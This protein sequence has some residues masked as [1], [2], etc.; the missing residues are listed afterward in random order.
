MHIFKLLFIFS[1]AFLSFINAEQFNSANVFKH[2][3]KSI[4]N[5]IESDISSLVKDIYLK[6]DNYPLWMIGK[7]NKAKIKP[8]LTSLKNPLF[9][10]KDKDFG[11]N[12]ARNLISKIHYFEIPTEDLPSAYGRIDYLLTFSFVSM[13]DFIVR[14][15]VDWNLV[16]EKIAALKTDKGI[17]ANWEINTKNMPEID[18]LFSSIK[19]GRIEEYFDSLIPMHNVYRELVEALNEQ[20]KLKKEIVFN[21][22]IENK[23]LTIITNLDKTKLYD[24]EFEDESIVINIPA[25]NMSYFKDGEQIMKKNVVVGRIDRPTP[26]FSDKIKYMVINPTWTIPKSLIKRDVVPSL[27]KNPDLIKQKNIR[28][29]VDGKEIAIN[30][31]MLIDY[32]SRNYKLPYKLIQNPGDLNALGRVKFIFPNKYSVFLHDTNHKNLFKHKER[33][34]SSGCIRLDKPF[35]L[36]HKLMEH[37]WSKKPTNYVD[38][39]LASEKTKNI[40]FKEPVPIHIIY[41]TVFKENGKIKFLKDIY[42]YDKFIQEA[43]FKNEEKKPFIVEGLH[44]ASVN[45]KISNKENN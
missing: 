43:A 29:F 5:S 39:V 25:F 4:D 41:F 20:K 12:E 40:Y 1:F 15:D 16:K 34:Y 32:K 26:I 42:S 33:S 6:N 30:E 8:L 44:F 2:I 21:K 11:Q 3:Q 45:E 28:A 27:L 31:E 38:S 17:E 22:N 9:N 23:I 18:L 35:E 19:E 10:Y 13:V 37:T 36:A 14:G 24:R 7:D